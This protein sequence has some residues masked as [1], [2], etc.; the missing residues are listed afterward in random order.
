MLAE[1]PQWPALVLDAAQLGR[2]FPFHL[3][4]DSG[5]R[6]QSLGPSLHKLLPALQPGEPVLAHFLPSH[7]ELGTDF[8]GW[9]EHL[10][11]LV[12]LKARRRPALTL[13]GVLERQGAQGLILLL[14]AV[15]TSYDEM[16]EF[17]LGLRDFA[18]HDSVAE[19]IRAR[20]NQL[21]AAQEADF[22]IARLVAR[23]EE[24][25]AM[26]ELGDNGI[27]YAEPDGRVTHVN[28]P[29]QQMFGIDASRVANLSLQDF[30]RHLDE[31][32][33]PEDAHSRPLSALLRALASCSGGDGFARHSHHIRLASPRRLTLQMSAGVTATGDIVLYF[34]DVTSE[35]EVDRMKSEFLSTAAHELRTPL[36]SI[37]G[38]AELMISRQMTP[39]RQ[40]E[41]LATIH[42][43]ARLL[44]NLINELLD[45]SRIE[46]RQG[47][48]F[49]RG[50]H[51]IETLVQ[52][53]LRGLLVR[54]DRRQ[55][56]LHLPQGGECIMVDPEKT[57]QALLNVLS[58]AFKYSP[59]GADIALQTSLK[60][61]EG[62]RYV[63][64]S[65][66][67]HGMGMTPEQLARVFERFWRAD[68]LGAI[69][70]TGLG[71]SLVKEIT[72]LQ[73]GHVEVAS[74]PGEGTT[75]TLWFP[76]VAD[77]VLSRP[78]EML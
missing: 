26:L 57:Q 70:G 63:G 1:D 38:F 28:L 65:V 37:F 8:H 74:V 54:D 13:R 20:H 6:V 51:R 53:T 5:L 68:P 7:P 71:M 55:V 24:L 39:E 48:D 9:C 33:A 12:I 3:T 47:K 75:V 73:E 15:V 66:R 22:R 62:E 56:R 32:L 27:L 14:S 58:N 69:P 42:R 17:G 31:M 59:G 76:L 52:Q 46:A 19:T 23:S 77:F 36:A 30:E 21:V 29:L 45:L 35:T 60:E 41:L 4:L 64:I 34:R 43:Q 25:R 49:H 2:A 40:K 50:H 16:R 78:S 11:E 67:D 44:M 10:G 72:E 61:A 18:L